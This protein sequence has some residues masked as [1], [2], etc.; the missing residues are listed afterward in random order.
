MIPDK[1]YKPER[2]AVNSV[3]G[4]KFD[5]WN[6]AVIRNAANSRYRITDGDGNVLTSEE[7]GPVTGAYYL[8]NQGYWVNTS[9]A[10]GMSWPITNLEEGDR[11]VAELTLAPEY[12]V[13]AKGNTNWDALG[14]GATMSFP[15]VVDNTA[16][17]LVD[18][19]YSMTS[20]ALT[21]TASDNQYVAAVVLFDA[22][23][24]QLLAS[25]GAYADIEPGEEAVYVLDMNGLSG[26]KFLLQVMDYAMN[27]TT[28]A[29]EAQ[30]GGATKLP[31]LIAYDAVVNKWIGFDTDTPLWRMGHRRPV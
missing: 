7:A 21:V 2:N 20:N 31:H 19:S 12:Y 8:V 16:P 24:S 18:V 3:R 11:I 13:D 17:E 26:R 30:I 5:V 29:V 4:D 23:G 27:V 9:M 25:A 28:Y 6:C 22:G 1:G 14:K 15:A 10:M